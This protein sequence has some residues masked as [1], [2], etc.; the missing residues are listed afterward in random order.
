M[1]IL[2]NISQ[3][4][5]NLEAFLNI[6]HIGTSPFTRN[7]LQKPSWMEIMNR[8]KVKYAGMLKHKNGMQLN[9]SLNPVSS[10]SS[11]FIFIQ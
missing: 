8:G 7:L 10:K 9:G 6:I 2:S 4:H 5:K 3:K 11:L 1:F